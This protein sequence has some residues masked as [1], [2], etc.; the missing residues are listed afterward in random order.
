MRKW[1][2]EVNFDGGLHYSKMTFEVIAPHS[3]SAMS[4]VYGDVMALG[5]KR[6][7]FQA[8]II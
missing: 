5:F 8:H 2:V 6:E 7:Q 3:K 4:M 1:T